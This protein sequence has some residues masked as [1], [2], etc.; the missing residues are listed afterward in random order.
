MLEHNFLHYKSL[1]K[2]PKIPVATTA[3]SLHVLWGVYTTIAVVIA[4]ETDSFWLHLAENSASH[5]C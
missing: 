1:N 5:S 2:F 3:T 4:V